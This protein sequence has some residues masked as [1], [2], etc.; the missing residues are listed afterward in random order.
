MNTGI[1]DAH[2]LGWKLALVAAGRA[3]GTL[4]DSY[5]TERRP[6]AEEVLKLTHTL[7]RYGIMSHPVKRRVRD[8]I[9]PALAHST[10]IQRHAAR[11]LTHVGVVYPAGPLARPD[12]WRSGPRPGQRIPDA[13]VRQGSEVTTLHKLL[14]HGRHVLVVPAADLA[15]V[16][17]DARLRPYQNDI[18]V[19]TS[20]ITEASRIPSGR[21]VPVVLV[22][23]DGHVAVRARP[24]TI[25]PV[26]DYL[27]DLFGEQGQP[28]PEP[29]T[30]GTLRCS[31]RPAA[32]PTGAVTTHSQ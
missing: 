9:V 19:V 10:A 32:V 12:S 4:L 17:D 14:R 7:V 13:A 31:A 23:P 27:H 28:V 30:A 21:T 2:N 11:R 20:N 15:N 1:M 25:D 16:L 22:R 8:M 29:A 18:N 3:P 5:G 26:I 24:A 6:V